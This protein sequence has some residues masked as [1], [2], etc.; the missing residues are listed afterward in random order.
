VGETTNETWVVVVA[1]N[2]WAE[3]TVDDLETIAVKEPDKEQDEPDTGRDAPVYWERPQQR[4]ANG[5]DSERRRCPMRA[6]SSFG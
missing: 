3:V 4:P 2:G 1:D 5:I 6:A